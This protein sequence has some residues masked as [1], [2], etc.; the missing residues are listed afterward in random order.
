[1]DMRLQ[2]A[3]AAVPMGLYAPV[4]HSNLKVILVD[5][6]NIKPPE[7]SRGHIPGVRSAIGTL[8][9]F[10]PF[11]AGCVRRL[12]LSLGDGVWLMA[13]E[14]VDQDRG[15]TSCLVRNLATNAN[16]SVR[17]REAQ[18]LVFQVSNSMTWPKTGRNPWFR[19]VLHGLHCVFW[20]QHGFC[21]ERE[22]QG[23]TRT[24]YDSAAGRVESEHGPRVELKGLAKSLFL[25]F[26]Y[27]FSSFSLDFRPR[28]G[29]SGRW[30]PL[31]HSPRCHLRWRV[32][33]LRSRGT[34]CRCRCGPDF[35]LV[36][37]F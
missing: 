11:S 1:M 30:W 20:P 35:T 3:L 17:L 36:S 21:E 23:C 8:A 10:R 25:M 15:V 9:L 31:C 16:Y 33:K 12:E 29:L 4:D 18:Q 22:S 7:V 2:H 37:F 24:D 6:C 19:E 27:R 13:S 34:P 32:C 26:F 28:I 14:C 5:I